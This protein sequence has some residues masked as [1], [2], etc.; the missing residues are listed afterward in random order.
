MDISKVGFST[1][2]PIDKILYES[3]VATV[4][5][6]AAPSADET[7]KITVTVPHE[8]GASVVSNLMFSVDNVNFYPMATRIMYNIAGQFAYTTAY[9]YAN[10]TSVSI[11]VSNYSPS[12]R[13]VYYYYN[14]EGI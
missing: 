6:A 14:L 4:A 10:D 9:G 3:P 7:A 8:F 11:H 1:Q 5:V 13:T 2:N 12:A